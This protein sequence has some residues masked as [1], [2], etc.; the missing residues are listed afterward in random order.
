MIARLNK[1]RSEGKPA[2]RRLISRVSS[3]QKSKSKRRKKEEE[4]SG[5]ASFT[6]LEECFDLQDISLTSI[7]GRL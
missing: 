7:L 5:D 1:Y 2:H 3:H 6:N 4:K